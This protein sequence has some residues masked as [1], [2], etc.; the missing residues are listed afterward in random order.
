MVQEF[1]HQQYHCVFFLIIVC[2]H[3]ITLITIDHYRSTCNFC[4]NWGSSSVKRH[5]SRKVTW[6]TGLALSLQQNCG[7]WCR[8][9]HRKMIGGLE[10][11][12]LGICGSHDV[13]K[14]PIYILWTEHLGKSLDQ[15]SQNIRSQP[16]SI[17]S[18]NVLSLNDGKKCAAPKG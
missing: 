1:S 18:W 12:T 2:E 11:T 15:Q 3:L 10:P 8:T 13:H 16:K 7:G 17:W 5:L 9:S 14:I 6:Y 4:R